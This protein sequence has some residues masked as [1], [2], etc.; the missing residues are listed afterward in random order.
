M[1]T[2]KV[3]EVANK[4]VLVLYK[5][6]DGDNYGSQLEYRTSNDLEHLAEWL[7]RFVP[8]LSFYDIYLFVDGVCKGFSSTETVA[9]KSRARELWNIE[10]KKDQ[11]ERERRN[12]ERMAKLAVDIEAAEKREYERLKAKFDKSLNE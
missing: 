12:A 3:V 8:S 5:E 6:A 1:E 9:L 4:Y 11:E 10:V 7:S 2:K